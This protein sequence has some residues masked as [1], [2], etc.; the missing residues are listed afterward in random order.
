MG[1]RARQLEEQILHNVD[2]LD[3]QIAVGRERRIGDMRALC[4]RFVRHEHET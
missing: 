3:R 1:G 4:G 2:L